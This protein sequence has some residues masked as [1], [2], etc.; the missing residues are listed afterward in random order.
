MW[1]SIWLWQ[2]SVKGT[3]AALAHNYL[4]LSSFYNFKMLIVSWLPLGLN[5]YVKVEYLGTFL[6][7]SCNIYY[8]GKSPLKVLSFQ[9]QETAFLGNG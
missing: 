9:S 7:D 1:Y 6:V 3:L 4:F 5:Y 2:G 8:D